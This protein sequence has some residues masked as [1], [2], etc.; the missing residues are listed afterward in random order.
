MVVEQT[1]GLKMDTLKI[2][3]NPTAFMK[4][5]CA[6][7]VFV[8]NDTVLKILHEAKDEESKDSEKNKP[9]ANDPQKNV[10]KLVV[11]KS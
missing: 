3:R 8:A 1:R 10:P 11:D 4:Q 5:D 9:A 6:E 7:P 2:I